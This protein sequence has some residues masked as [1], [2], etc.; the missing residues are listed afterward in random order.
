MT[1]SSGQSSVIML[2]SSLREM[3]LN[4]LFRSRKAAARVGRACAVYGAV[5]YFSM[6]SW[7]VLIMKSIPPS[8][9]MA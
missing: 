5:T 6:L 7:T 4:M 8:T 3:L 9:P 2:S 1:R